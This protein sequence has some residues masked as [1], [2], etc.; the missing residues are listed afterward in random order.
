MSTRPLNRTECPDAPAAPVR[1]V[2]L[3]LGAFHRAHQLW[4]TQHAETDPSDPQWGYAS[5]TG[6]S[7]RMSDLLGEQDGLF[8]LMERGPQDDRPEIIGALVDPGPP[9][10]SS[11]SGSCWPPRRRPW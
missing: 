3:G 4:Y 10:T 5:F 11:A 1:L 6:R 2:H 7:P 8:T 9:T